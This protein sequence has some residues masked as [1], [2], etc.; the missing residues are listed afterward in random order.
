L[1]DLFRR[2]DKAITDY[3]KTDDAPLILAGDEQIHPLYH[4]PNNYSHLV[5]VGIRLGAEKMSPKQLLDYVLPIVKPVFRR[6]E[7]A[8]RTF[9]E[10]IETGHASNNLAKIFA[11]AK[12]GRIEM[13]LVPVE[14]QKWG[15]FDNEIG[16]LIVHWEAKPGDKDLL[17]LASTRIL[18]TA[19]MFLFSL[20]NKC[21][22][23]R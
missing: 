16:E 15:T 14:R 19:A 6:R 23:T 4:D 7:K 11:V 20:P 2:V 21:R 1:L 18:R 10:K 9:R 22:T 5:K 12:T 8:L 13:L 17:C 3:L